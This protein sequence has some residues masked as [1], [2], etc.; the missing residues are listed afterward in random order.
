MEMEPPHTPV[1]P[2]SQLRTLCLPLRRA[3]CW[4]CLK[5][6]NKGK[7]PDTIMDAD[8]GGRGGIRWGLE[9][10]FG[11]WGG[12]VESTDRMPHKGT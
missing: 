2:L 3:L 6:R 9:G 7:T 5:A 8:G 12:W 1:R 4:N 10:G 11:L